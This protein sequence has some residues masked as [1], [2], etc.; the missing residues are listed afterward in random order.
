MCGSVHRLQRRF[1]IDDILFQS[2]D[3]RN[4][5]AT[6][7]EIAPKLWYFWA[8]NFWGEGDPK[9]LTQFYK[10]QSPSNM[11]QILVTLGQEEIRRRKKDKKDLTLAAYYNGRRPAR[12]RAAIIK[13]EMHIVSQRN[14]QPI[15]HILEFIFKI[16]WRL[17]TTLQQKDRWTHVRGPEHSRRQSLI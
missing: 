6:K 1:P 16:W 2:G 4:Q 11:W 5:V 10:L 13:R 14:L 12:W 15:F 7:T 3:I 8:T 9:F 17:V